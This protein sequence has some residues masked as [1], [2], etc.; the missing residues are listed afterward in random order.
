M[1]H[2][3]KYCTYYA[4]HVFIPYM[5]YGKKEQLKEMLLIHEHYNSMEIDIYFS[6]AGK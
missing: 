3:Y 1:V 2:S 5:I 4:H 6:Y